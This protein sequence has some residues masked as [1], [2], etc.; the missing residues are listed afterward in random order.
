MGSRRQVIALVSRKYGMAFAAPNLEG[1]T[2]MTIRELRDFID[3]FVDEDE[4]DL[5]VNLNHTTSFNYDVLDRG[6]LTVIP[7]DGLEILV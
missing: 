1:R 6:S 5:P 4:L 3:E 7:G 2:Q